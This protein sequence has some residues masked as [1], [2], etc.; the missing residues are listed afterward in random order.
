MWPEKK[1]RFNFLFR[2]FSTFSFDVL[3]LSKKREKRTDFFTQIFEKQEKKR[4]K[5]RGG[6]KTK[7]SSSNQNSQRLTISSLLSKT[8]FKN[9]TYTK[10]PRL[11]RNPRRR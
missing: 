10:W 11:Q 4:E 3:L 7:F 6:A 2:F 1:R 5:K 8:V 9:N